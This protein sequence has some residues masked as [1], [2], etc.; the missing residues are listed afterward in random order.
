MYAEVESQIQFSKKT[1]NF[2]DITLKKKRII[3]DITTTLLSKV[4][5]KYSRKPFS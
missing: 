3:W 2:N 4:I 5:S 1:K